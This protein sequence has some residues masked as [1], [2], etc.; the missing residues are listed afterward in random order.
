[1]GSDWENSFSVLVQTKLWWSEFSEKQSTLL[2]AALEQKNCILNCIL[3]W[4]R[5]SVQLEKSHFSKRKQHHRS[6][7]AADV[8][9]LQV[10]LLFI[11]HHLTSSFAAL[12]NTTDTRGHHVSINVNTCRIKLHTASLSGDFSEDRFP[13]F[14]SVYFQHLDLPYAK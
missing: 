13:L 8:P 2:V 4:R 10:L 14:F 11:H 1:M 7:Q 5:G 6:I 9:E 12:I 3:L